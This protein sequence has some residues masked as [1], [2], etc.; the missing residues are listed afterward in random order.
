MAISL[1]LKKSWRLWGCPCDMENIVPSSESLLKELEETRR[2]LYEAQETIEAIRTGQVD[3]LVVQKGGGHELYTLKS[4]DRAYRV[5]IEKM[6]EG[7]VTLNP[8]GMILYANSQFA[9]MT[10]APL[11]AILGLAFEQFIAVEDRPFF[12]SLFHDCWQHDCKGEVTINGKKGTTAVKL[13]LTP[14]EL[15]EGISLSI[16]ITDLTSQKETQKQ[17]EENNRQL[18]LLNKTLEASNHDLQQF[19]SVASH[20]LQ[21]PL[22]KIQLFAN[23]LKN[24]AENKLDT[25]EIRSLDKVIGSASRMKTLIIDVLNYSKLS[26]N[27]GSFCPTDLNVLVRDLLEDFEMMIEEKDAAVTCDPLPVLE[28]NPGQIRQVFQ[29]LVS[30]ALKFSKKDTRPLIT[31]TARRLAQKSFVSAEQNDGPYCLLSVKDNGIGFDEKYIPNVFALFER[32][33]PKE[34]Y[35]GTGI[36]LAIAKKIVEKHQGLI[37][38]KT[39]VGKGSEFRILLPL[40]HHS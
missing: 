22:R 3:A 40:K 8:E 12:S 15:E 18:E 13:S 20:D 2:Q 11:S 27:D 29:N 37:Q 1:K 33:H 35:E 24:R 7:A 21:E 6:T 17:L 25:D 36:G 23:L 34:Q 4:A 30:N 19:A 38:V 26:A 32:L 28:V 5:F 10:A 31:I 14:L 9:A 16:I 39:A